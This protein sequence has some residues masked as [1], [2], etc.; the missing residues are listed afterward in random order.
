VIRINGLDELKSLEGQELGPGPWRTITQKMIDAFADATDDHQWIH[1]D[2]A[3]A[4]KESPFGKTIA[5]GY[6]T[7]SLFVSMQEEIWTISGVSRGVNYGADKL[8]FIAPVVV[9]SR[10]RMNQR[11]Q[12]VEPIP[13]GARLTL[14]STVQIESVEKPALVITSIGLLYE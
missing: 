6:L 8:R 2:P 14:E 13:G 1:C 4:A 3:R 9:D 12:S 11:V 5:H 7:L 10:I